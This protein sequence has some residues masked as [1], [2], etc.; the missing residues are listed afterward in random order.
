MAAPPFKVKAIYEYSSGHDEDL[1]FSVGDV[2]TVIELE[3]DD[4]YVGKYTDASGV[5]KEGL[6]PTNFVERYEPEVPTRPTRPTRPKQ[7]AAQPVPVPVPVPAPE[8]EE[9]EEVQSVPAA[10]R[11][12]VPPVDKPAVARHQEDARSPTSA[13]SQ[14]APSAAFEPPHVTKAAPAANDSPAASRAAPPPVAPKSSSFKDRIAAFNKVEQQPLKPMVPG[15][16]GPAG[17][18]IKKPFVAPPPS[19]SSYIPPVVKHEPIHRPYMREEDPEIKRQQEDDRAAAEAAGLLNDGPQEAAEEA[20]NEPKP[21]SLKERMALLQE[22]QRL[23]AERN[24]EASQRKEKKTVTKKPSQASVP[25]Q[26][27]EED[28]DD[29]EQIS[30]AGTRDRPSMESTRERPPVPSAPRRTHEPMSP[31]PAVPQHEIVSGGE[32]ADQSA[33]GETTEDDADTIAPDYDDRSTHGLPRA[34]NAPTHEPDVGN[35]DDTVEDDEAEEEEELNEE[36]LRKQRLRERMARLAGPQGGAGVPFNPFGAPPPPPTKKRS[37]TRKASGDSEATMPPP[38]RVPIMPMPGMQR[39]RSQD[40]NVTERIHEEEVS[41]PGEE[42]EH[43]FPPVRRSMTG[44]RGAAPPVPKDRPVPELPPQERSAPPPLPSDST[45]PRNSTE[46]RAVPQPPPSAVPRSPGPGSE[47][48]DERSMHARMFS[49]E[50]S[51]IDTSGAEAALPIRTGGM[52]SPQ[53]L[54]P[55]PPQSPESKRASY[56]QN[57]PISAT[58]EK[59]HSRLPPPIPVVPISSRPPPPPP[60]TAAPPSRQATGS[61]QSKL[62][63][64]ERGESEYEGDYDTDIA[65]SAK[66]KDALKAHA[67]E[68]SLDDSTIADEISNDQIPGAVP[69]MPPTPGQQPRAVPPPPPANKNTPRSRPSIDAPRAPP[70]VPP[71]AGEGPEVDYDPYRYN[72]PNQIAPPVPGTAPIPVLPTSQE[73]DR[74]ESS[75]DELPRRSIDRAP[76]PPPHT[77]SSQ[78][79]ISHPPPPPP[80]S[81]PQQAPPPGEAP[82]RPSLQVQHR[83]SATGRRSTDERPSHEQ[84]AADVDLAPNTTWWA[85]PHPLPPVFQSRNGIDILSESEESTTTKRGGRS[86]ISKDIYVLFMDYSQTIITARYDSRDV[87]DVTLEQRHEPAPTRL[88]QDQLE[89]YWQRFG[90]KIAEA[91]R[92]AA[93]GKK[94]TVVGDGTPAAL[95]QN[96]IAS[97]P[98]ALL[99]VGTRGY[100]A[101]IYSNLANATHTQVDEIRPGD[102]ITV[103]NAKFEGHHGAMRQKYKQDFGAS[104]VAV[105]EEWDGTKRAVRAWEQG[106][107]KKGGVRS[108][109]FRL[110]D[111]RSGEVRVW[112][113]VGRDWVGWE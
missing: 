87:S 50:T 6:F 102:I 108:E 82:G 76:P 7:E 101:L 32:E 5:A 77:A 30:T 91:A 103:R 19:S 48:D 39:V 106:R 100:G 16:Q 78:R 33:A 1:S 64:T 97:Q 34:S 10:S 4:W 46:V 47:S 68:P 74:D 107:E 2:I 51:G 72:G 88:R 11:P 25:P 62:D 38:Q 59:R 54:P 36:E 98:S 92:Q 99:P 83:T 65:S 86:T 45:R 105:V 13:T 49:A 85:A 109:K 104:H 14:N 93:G 80:P 111:L 84:I 43:P 60:P 41:T 15:K 67:R 23:A 70:P 17:G 3:G 21:M 75:A 55:R 8:A 95:P 79:V 40:S 12:Q 94:D 112:R 69:F 61:E 71:S 37:I 9:Q 63:D 42:T 110:G 89:N 18:F 22:Q 90:T 35:Q 24:A 28:E 52:S 96:L 29:E 81:A 27:T 56:F 44:E 73:D 58:S 26:S 113:V 66:H 57:E 53:S 31:G 20:E